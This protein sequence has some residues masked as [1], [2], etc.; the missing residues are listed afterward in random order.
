MSDVPEGETDRELDDAIVLSALGEVVPQLEVAEVQLLG[1][2][3]DFDTYGVGLRWVARFPRRA[4]V[5]RLLHAEVQLLPVLEAALQ[6]LAIEVPTVYAVAP[7]TATFPHPFL[8]Q[9]RLWGLP[10]ES[11]RPFRFSVRLAAHLG[12]ALSVVH[13]LTPPAELR[14]A[15]NDATTQLTHATEAIDAMSPKLRARIPQAVAWIEDTPAL[16]TAYNGPPRLLHNRLSP[17]RIRV[18]RTGLGL[19]GILD[20]SDVAAGDPARDL[21]Q[22]HCWGGPPAV[23]AVLAAYTLELDEGLPERVRFLARVTSITTLRDVEIA[24]GDTEEHVAPMLE[25]YANE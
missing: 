24:G 12:E 7:A 16:P 21:V 17:G 13:G 9:R 4:A 10:L 25:S 18:A 3:R 19:I 22:L 23:E 5:A 11:I 2:G 20:W 1:S 6:P 15:P 8:V 14:N